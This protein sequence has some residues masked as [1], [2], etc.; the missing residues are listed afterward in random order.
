MASYNELNALIDAYINRNGVQAITGQI[1]NGVLKAMVEQLGRGYTIMGVALP[2]TDPGTPDGPESWF[3]STPGTYTDMGGLTVA[4][5]ELA[6]LSYTP[7][8]GWAK[9]TLTQGITEVQATIDANVGIPEV[10]ADYVNGVLY[11]DFKNLKGTQGVPGPTGPAAGFGTP[12]ASVDGN[13]GTPGV[14]VTASGPD[15]AKVFSFAFTNLKGDQGRTGRADGTCGRYLRSRYRGQHIGES[16]L[17]GF[18]RLRCPYTRLHGAEGRT[19]RHGFVRGLSVHHRKQ[20]HNGRCNTGVVR[21]DGCSV[22]G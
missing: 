7:S 11:F 15:T 17:H 14:S 2:T 22:G 19:G 4:N 1:L 12:T 18:P 20:P 9:T 3:A 21:R 10:S 13:V 6:L 5:A 16:Y 8:D